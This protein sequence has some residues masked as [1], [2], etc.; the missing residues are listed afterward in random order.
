MQTIEQKSPPFF[1][2]RTSLGSQE[3]VTLEKE[4]EIPGT[5][6]SLPA[7]VV[8]R[9]DFWPSDSTT[10]TDPEV[11][12]V[13]IEHDDIS[14][15]YQCSSSGSSLDFWLPEYYTDDMVFQMGPSRHNVWG[16]S[17]STECPIFVKETCDDGTGKGTETVFSKEAT[18]TFYS[19]SS[20]Y[21]LI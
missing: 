8:P 20:K 21:I 14:D 19:F 17:N 2:G 1:S 11:S 7:A 12:E 6:Q 3:N 5:Q 4:L 15:E 9:E 16:M 10:T 13:T 18:D